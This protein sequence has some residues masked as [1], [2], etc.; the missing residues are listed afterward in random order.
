MMQLRIL[1]WEEVELH[2]SFFDFL[3]WFKEESRF[4]NVHICILK[5]KVE[6]CLYLFDS[7]RDCL[8]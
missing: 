2:E 1:H 8:V 3:E 5:F 7:S 4:D 6:L